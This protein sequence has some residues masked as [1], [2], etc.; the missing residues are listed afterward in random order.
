MIVSY[1]QG[2]TCIFIRLWKSSIFFS[3]QTRVVFSF[4]AARVGDTPAVAPARRVFRQCWAERWRGAE[5][6]VHVGTATCKNARPSAQSAHA[7]RNARDGGAGDARGVVA[8]FTAAHAGDA[9]QLLCLSTNVAE[10]RARV[11]SRRQSFDSEPGCAFR[12]ARR[13]PPT[14]FGRSEACRARMRR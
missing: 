7:K 6:A 2:Q 8:Q 5:C 14:L 4:F 9:A 10:R 11:F 3:Q 13:A 12:A 1:R